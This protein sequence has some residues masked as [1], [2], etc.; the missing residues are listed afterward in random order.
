MHPSGRPG[1]RPRT[2]K[3]VQNGHRDSGEHA[4][5]GSHH[6]QGG[7]PGEGHQLDSAGGLTILGWSMHH[8]YAEQDSPYTDFAQQGGQWQEGRQGHAKRH[9]SMP[10]ILKR[11]LQA[12]R[13][14]IS[15]E[16]LPRASGSVGHLGIVPMCAVPRSRSD[17]A[18]S[19]SGLEFPP[20][21]PPP[22]LAADIMSGPGAPVSKA[23]LWCGWK[24]IPI[25][26]V[27]SNS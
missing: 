22:P 12:E 3:S 1:Y 18:S 17:G 7:F 19:S 24:V 13:R 26:I 20:K 10:E 11:R 16:G 4:D 27:G 14:L 23:L 9:D 2:R 15:A 8:L 25:D 5:S 6:D 21:P